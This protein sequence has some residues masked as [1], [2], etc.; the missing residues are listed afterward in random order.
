MYLLVYNEVKQCNDSVLREM[1]R[2]Q[3]EAL[4]KRLQKYSITKLF[5]SDSKRAIETT[6]KCGTS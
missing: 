3:E 2:W 6:Q 5:S 4:G 1:G